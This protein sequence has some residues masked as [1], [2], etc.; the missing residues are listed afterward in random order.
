[1]Y[2][3]FEVSSHH[4]VCMCWPYCSPHFQD[5]KKP[6]RQSLNIVSLTMLPYPSLAAYRNNH[7]GNLNHTCTAWVIH[8]ISPLSVIQLESPDSEN[9]NVG[10]C[11]LWS[12]RSREHPSPGFSQPAVLALAGLGTKAE[13]KQHDR[14]RASHPQRGV[15]PRPA[16][17]CVALGQ[18]WLWTSEFAASRA[19][20]A[21]LSHRTEPLLHVLNTIKLS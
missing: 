16:P 8:T 7:S 6:W 11:E 2:L 3:K 9:T 4:G 20:R 1:M 18:S 5:E 19:R 14:H 13:T 17:P 12:Y 21:T 15:P 10:D